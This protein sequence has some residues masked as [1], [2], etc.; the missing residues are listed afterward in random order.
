[1]EP[2]NLLKN[3]SDLIE[4]LLKCII[5]SIDED[6][7]EFVWDNF[8][9]KWF[10]EEG[11]PLFFLFKKNLSVTNTQY[12]ELFALLELHTKGTFLPGQNC[13]LLCYT[14]DH[15][16]ETFTDVMITLLEDYKN[17]DTSRIKSFAKQYLDVF[18]S[19]VAVDMFFGSCAIFLP[20]GTNCDLEKIVNDSGYIH[21]AG[22]SV[23]IRNIKKARKADFLS[24]VDIHL[25]RYPSN[26][27]QIPFV[28]YSHED[29]SDYDKDSSDQLER[30]IG[31]SKLYVEKMSM[32]SFRLS[33]II[34][35]LEKQFKDKLIVP[36]AGNYQENHNFTKKDRTIW[37]ICDKSITSGQLSNPGPNRYY[38]CYEQ[39]VKN[40]S[41]LYF[42]DENKP[43]WKS[44]TTL[45]HSLTAALLNIARPMSN[46]KKI[47][48]PFG[49]AGTTWLEVKR[50]MLDTEI[51]S[52]D[53]S[54]ATNLLT[55]D[56]LNFFTMTADEL[57]ELHHDILQ[58]HPK[59]IGENKNAYNKSENNESKSYS[60]MYKLLTELKKLQK[61]T[62]EEYELHKQFVKKLKAKT[63]S[64]RVNF[65]IGLRAE[66]RFK[67]AFERKS[68]TFED[69]FNKSKEKI[70][71]QIKMLIDLRRVL[72]AAIKSRKFENMK[73]YYKTLAN[74]SYRLTPSF[75]FE[76]KAVLLN[77][78]KKEVRSLKDARKLPKGKF[79]LIICDPPYGF[80]TTEEDCSLSTLYSEF[81]DKAIESLRVRGQLI[82]C[83]PAESYTGKGLPYCTRSDLVSRQILTKAHLMG[84][85]VYKT[86]QSLPLNSFSPPYYWEAERALKRTILHFRF[87]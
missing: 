33:T 83:L 63:I 70:S 52:S 9:K 32:G 36:H 51:Y 19:T 61:T 43:A 22:R 38:I 10:R 86:T 74:Y 35:D 57:E 84:R 66:L 77:K 29:F 20:P 50:L 12:V 16:K 46:I 11:T 15:I 81:I 60:E 45:P 1:M 67:N 75:L 62:T 72:E 58:C 79:D 2:N 48:D 30:G 26:D 17:V 42:F 27:G 18:C 55:E 39:T 82:L 5:E 54:P 85:L 31:L 8:F 59:E 64:C 14:T 71:N 78:L 53:L 13:K 40:D 37:L 25:Q 56:N 65:Y 21:S 3:R 73:S 76:E 87:I 23:Y 6:R 69:A 44:H 4:L 80:N 47:C 34:I 24:N 41:P 7:T 68:A 49:G 28:P